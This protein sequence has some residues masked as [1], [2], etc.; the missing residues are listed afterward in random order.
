MEFPPDWDVF[1]EEDFDMAD[2]RNPGEAG[3]ELMAQVRANGRILDHFRLALGGSELLS[4]TVP[5]EDIL[6]A[7]ELPRWTLT[8]TSWP[9]DIK[10]RRNM[11]S[12]TW[13]DVRDLVSSNDARLEDED[14]KT[15]EG[16]A[17][18][19]LLDE[20][21]DKATNSAAIRWAVGA[22]EDNKMALTLQALP[23]P[24][25]SFAGKPLFK[26]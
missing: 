26:G 11:A 7:K 24:A 8:V 15:V 10:I 18:L 19:D 9:R 1:P 5:L 17:F 13:V 16:K 12:S 22:G 14:K 6:Q 25:H 3:V 4:A 21:V 23:C 2:P 20:M